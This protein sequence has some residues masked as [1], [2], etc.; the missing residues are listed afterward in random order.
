MHSVP[1]VEE[2]ICSGTAAAF[3]SARYWCVLRASIPEGNG[4]VPSCPGAGRDST[5]W[6]RPTGKVPRPLACAHP[7]SPAP[8]LPLSPP[9]TPAPTLAP[10]L[11]TGP[12]LTYYYFLGLAACT[13]AHGLIPLAPTL[14]APPWVPAQDLCPPDAHGLTPVAGTEC[15]L[16]PRTQDIKK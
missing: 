15:P 5:P 10:C 4:L 13:S 8:A 14:T 11:T 3:C 1:K 9:G 7:P 6:C 12:L 2:A 16:L